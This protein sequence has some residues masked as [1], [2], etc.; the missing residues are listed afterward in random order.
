MPVKSLPDKNSRPLANEDG[1]ALTEFAILFPFQ[2]L[3]IG[4]II[5]MCLIFHAHIVVNQAA[6]KAARAAIV[7]DEFEDANGRT[8]KV[9]RAAVALCSAIAGKKGVNGGDLIRY[10]GTGN[11]GTL[12]RS[13]ASAAKTKVKIQYDSERKALLAVVQHE[14]EL[15]VPVVRQIFQDAGPSGQFGNPHCTVTESYL[16]PVPW[17]IDANF[18]GDF[19]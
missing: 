10:P 17:F 1:Q 3:L 2:Y 13:G 18:P 7:C 15:H 5:Q 6:F 8:E 19:Y 4:G 14:L 12:G 11:K 9:K 16:M